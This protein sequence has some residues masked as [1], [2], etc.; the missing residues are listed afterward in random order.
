MED[1]T[2][3]TPEQLRVIRKATP[4]LAVTFTATTI[5]G[6]IALWVYSTRRVQAELD[7]LPVVL[8]IIDMLGAITIV[9]AF[10]SI[11]RPSVAISLQ[12]AS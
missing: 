7:Q 12:R 10:Y 4:R 3:F 6:G 8:M 9:P 2:I 1:G 5:I 11:F